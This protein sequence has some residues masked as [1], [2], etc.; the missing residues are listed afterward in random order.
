MNYYLDRLVRFVALRIAKKPKGLEVMPPKQRKKNVYRRDNEVLVSRVEKGEDVREMIERSVDL[1]GGFEKIIQA[2][3][4]IMLKPNY[5]RSNPP[6]ASTSL[7]FLEA[8]ILSLKERGAKVIVGECSGPPF[9]TRNVLEERGTKNL[10]ERLGA[11][12]IIFNEDEW[13]EVNNLGGDY[14]DRI[15]MPKRAYGVDKMVYLS[16]MKTHRKARFSLSLKLAVG[17]SHPS[18]RRMLHDGALEEK[19]AEINLVWQPDI[20]I[21]DGRKAFI[22]GG[23]DDGEV[24]KPGVIMASGDMVAIDSEALGILKGYRADNRLDM[25][26]HEFP[27]IKVALARGLGKGDYTVVK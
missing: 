10:L 8:V 6:P 13:L 24:V 4:T 22:T 12:L 21:M 9:S 23:P 25:I 2:G 16:N 27:Q 19:V 20:I 26:P 18:E 5:N 7:D 14:L 17:F 3:Q 15:I 1:L 11:E